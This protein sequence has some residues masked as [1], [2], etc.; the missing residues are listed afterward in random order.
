M[1]LTVG[2]AAFW[3]A[4]SFCL[5]FALVWFPRA[6]LLWLAS[7]LAWFVAWLFWPGMGADLLVGVWIVV[8]ILAAKAAFWLW[9]ARAVCRSLA[10]R[11]RGAFW[12]G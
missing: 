9:V 3:I 10:D 12:S 8:T 6:T 5:G 11:A 1:P 2:A 7:S 4:A